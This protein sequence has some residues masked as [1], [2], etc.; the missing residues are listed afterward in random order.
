MQFPRGDRRLEGA[1][2]FAVMAAVGEAAVA[3]E[4]GDLAKATHQFGRVVQAQA[5]TAHPRGVDQVAPPGEVVATGGG[6]GVTTQAGG[7][8]Q[9]PDLDLQIRQ[10][11][12]D[13]GGFANPGLA[14]Q[15]AGLPRESFRQG[16]QALAAVEA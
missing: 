3:D 9:P 1:A 7:L 2:R 15:D 16:C 5:K 8:G 14:H 4:G 12:L 13:Q 10:Q 11:G 6:G